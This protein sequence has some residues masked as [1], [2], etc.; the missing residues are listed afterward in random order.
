MNVRKSLLSVVAALSALLGA[1]AE[2]DGAR[3][4]AP[5]GREASAG[6]G[7]SVIGSVSPVYGHTVRQGDVQRI[8]FA[9]KDGAR[10]D[11]VVLSIGERRIAALD[12]AGYDYA[13]A[14]DH[15][16]GRLIYRLTAYLDGRSE[17]RTGE[18][19]VLAAEA[20]SLYGYRVR[21]VFPHDRGHYTQG[22]LWHDGCLYEST[23]IEGRSA[24]YKID[25]ASGEAL[26]TEPLDAE[27]FGEG[28]ALLDGKFY[29]LTWQN[30]KALVYDAGTF[31]KTGEFGYAGEGWGLATDGRYLY[32][33]DGS[34]KIHVIDPE[35]FRRL[36]TIEVYTDRSKV[37]YINEMEWIDGELW[38]NVY[39]TDT[40]VRIDPRT[41]VVTGIVDMSGLLSEADIDATTDVLNGIAYDAENDRIFVTGK[42]WNKLFEITTVKE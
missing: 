30:N 35:G 11:S 14:K 9:L 32:M 29:L 37:P 28:L 40:I 23:G 6:A 13:V 26:K 3:S 31:E 4:D 15:P 33:S 19:T 10:A 5:S 25:L 39:T 36:R 17:S 2:R 7:L 12:T 16:A 18:F 38:A 8:A 22:L 34:E 27:L 24:L 21:N 42:N 1:C 20:P 41:G